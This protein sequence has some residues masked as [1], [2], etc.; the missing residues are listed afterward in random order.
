MI[1]IALIII[2]AIK[3]YE[4]LERNDYR[5]A[6]RIDRK[7]F[8]DCN[9][10]EL[11]QTL[12][13]SNERI[14]FEKLRRAVGDIY[15]IYPQVNLDKIFKTKFQSSRKKIFYEKARIDRKSID[16]LVTIRNSQTPYIGIELDDATHFRE[17]RVSRDERVNTLFAKKGIKLIRI[18]GSNS[19]SEE[20]L[21]KIFERD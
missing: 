4:R 21:R 9:N 20:E 6:D 8:F 15:D 3:F 19:V 1:V 13:T 7:N 14:F 11:R 18:N 16:F 17:D 12:M 10:Y 5:N 2:A